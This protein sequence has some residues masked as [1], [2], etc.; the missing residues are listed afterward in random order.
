MGDHNLQHKKKNYS[1]TFLMEKSSAFVG[2]FFFFFFACHVTLQ[3]KV[4]SQSVFISP[5][6]S[7]FQTFNC[8]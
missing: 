4:V 2:S 5:F 6:C 8:I 1:L 3:Q 7:F